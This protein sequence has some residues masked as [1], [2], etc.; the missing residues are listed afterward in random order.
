GS[1]IRH[2]HVGEDGASLGKIEGDECRVHSDLSKI[3]AASEKFR[4]D[5]TNLVEH[6]AQLAE[7]VDVLGD[8]WMD[9]VWYVVPSQPPTSLTDGQISLRPV[10]RSIDAVAVRPAASFVS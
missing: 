1:K 4:V 6:F 7:V 9:C 5:C 10:S 3:L 8:L 2:D